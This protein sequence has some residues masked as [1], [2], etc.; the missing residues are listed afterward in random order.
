MPPKSR[1]CCHFSTKISPNAFHR[2][3]VNANAAEIANRRYFPTQKRSKTAAMTSS[4]YRQ[5]RGG[6]AIFQR[7]P[8]RKRFPDCSLTANAAEI[9][10]RRYFPTQNRSKTAAITSSDA[11]FPD[12]SYTASSAASS[13]TPTAS[14]V[15]PACAAESACETCSRARK[16][17]LR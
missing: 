17:Q 12:S 5:N 3:L 16:T 7:K 13:S 8:H 10:S 1:S 15:T 4:I 14:G 9:A 6:A 2:L 11:R